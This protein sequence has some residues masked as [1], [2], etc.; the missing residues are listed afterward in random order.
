MAPDQEKWKFVSS[1]VS[2]RELSISVGGEFAALMGFWPESIPV[3][4]RPKFH[5]ERSP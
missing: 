1:P 4:R 5:D 3:E 2:S